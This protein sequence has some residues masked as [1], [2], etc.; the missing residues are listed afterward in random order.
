VRGN[1]QGVAIILG[2]IFGALHRLILDS[3]SSTNSYSNC[4]SEMRCLSITRQVRHQNRYFVSP[5]GPIAGIFLLYC[6]VSAFQRM[7]AISS[8]IFM[9]SFR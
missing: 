5:P 6:P 7:M 8:S 1:R 2:F 4:K 9:P 3:K